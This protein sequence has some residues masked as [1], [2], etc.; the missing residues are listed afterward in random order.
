MIIFT[1]ICLIVITVL[2]LV[3]YALLAISAEE[4]IKSERMYEEWKNGRNKDR[5]H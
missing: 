1:I 2:L 3:C 5:R 4:D